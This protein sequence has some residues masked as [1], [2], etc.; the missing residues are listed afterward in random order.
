MRCTKCD[1]EIGRNKNC[2]FCGT[3][4]E[5]HGDAPVSQLQKHRKS[6]LNLCGTL[7]IAVLVFGFIFSIYTAAKFG[8][9]MLAYTT[10]RNIV[11]TIV[12][13][14]SGMFSTVVLYVILSTLGEIKDTL[15]SLK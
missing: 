3:Y 14:L 8:V 1:K 6:D 4:N 15:D 7:S 9:D 13:F 5:V 11:S 2:P 10:E 12:I